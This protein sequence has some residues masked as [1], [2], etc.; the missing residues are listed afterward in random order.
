MEKISQGL[1]QVKTGSAE[2]LSRI[3]LPHF[4]D[5]VRDR[6]LQK[7]PKPGKGWKVQQEKEKAV[8]K[9]E[10]QDRGREMII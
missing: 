7:G 2:L 10:L 3:V 1:L 6:L 9:R 8:L 4:A 5:E